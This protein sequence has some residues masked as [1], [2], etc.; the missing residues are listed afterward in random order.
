MPLSS[1]TSPGCSAAIALKRSSALRSPSS[2]TRCWCILPAASRRSAPCWPAAQKFLPKSRSISATERPLMSATAP[3]EQA[4]AHAHLAGVEEHAP[5]P[6]VHVEFLDEAA[7]AAHP[8]ALLRGRH[9]ERRFQGTRAL[10]DVVGIDDQGF[11]K[12]SRRPRELAENEHPAL[13]VA[14]GDELLGDEV[15][16]VVQAAHETQL[17][18]PV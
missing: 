3:P 9:R 10:I 4:R 12:L 1:S 7:H 8:V 15:H 14:R 13:V 18:P 5:G 16:A 17:R 2:G 11:R 6:A